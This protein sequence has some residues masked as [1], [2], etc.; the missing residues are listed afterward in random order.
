MRFENIIECLIEWSIAGYASSLKCKLCL[1]ENHWIIKNPNNPNLLNKRSELIN[2][3][4]HQ[5][6]ILLK[7]V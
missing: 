5:D 3:C 7:T 2:K 6:K 1:M 4:R